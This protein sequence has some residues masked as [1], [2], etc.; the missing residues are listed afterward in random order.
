MYNICKKLTK[1]IFSW[2]AVGHSFNPVTQEAEV[3]RWL[4]VWSHPGLQR[5]KQ[6]SQATWSNPT[7][8]KNFKVHAHVNDYSLIIL[9]SDKAESFLL[10][11]SL[12]N[13]GFKYMIWPVTRRNWKPF[14]NSANIKVWHARNSLMK[15]HISEC[16]TAS[17][18]IFA[19]YSC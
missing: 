4:W 14:L 19:F 17:V 12:F 5:K 7:L 6:D 10:T 15:T 16:H 11:N 3:G 9:F 13:G 2:A 1:N 18:G 8:K